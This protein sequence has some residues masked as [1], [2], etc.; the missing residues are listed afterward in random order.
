MKRIALAATVIVISLATGVGAVHAAGAT[1]TVTIGPG[2]VAAGGDVTVS[3]C[4]FA[5]GNGGYYTVSGPSVLGTRFWGPA[6]G[7][8]CLTYVEAT[9]GWTP[10]KY[11]FIAYLT[12]PTGHNTKVGSAVV[13]VAS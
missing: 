4:N 10:G 7:Q 11:R 12:G 3:F 8:G 2:T 9:A 5:T 1:G 13:T 6:T